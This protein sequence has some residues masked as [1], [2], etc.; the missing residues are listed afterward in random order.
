MV[1]AWRDHQGS[2][3]FEDHQPAQSFKKSDQYRSSSKI[4]GKVCEESE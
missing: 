1:D 2:W 4:L 3:H